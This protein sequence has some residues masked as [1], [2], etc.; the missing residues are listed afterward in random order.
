M[1]YR[2][3]FK[4]NFYL[5]A[6][7]IS[8]RNLKPNEILTDL[9][10][11]KHNYLRVSL[12]ERCNLRCEY[13]MP[14]DGAKL[15][16]KND[17][18]TNEEM[19]KLVSLFV[20]QGINKVR[21]T[22]GEP[23]VR[24]DIVDIVRSLKELN[25]LRTIAMTTNGLTLTRTLVNLQRAGLNALNIS[26]DTLQSQKYEKITRRDGGLL[27][28]VLVGIDLALQLG[29]NPVKVNCVLM[30]KFNLSEL[31][32]FVEFTR[33]LNVDY[34]FIEFMP[35]AMN[36]WDE[37]QLVPY[38]EAVEIITK[39][40]PNFQPCADNNTNATSKMFKVPEFKGRVGFITS[41]TDDYCDGCNRLRLMADGNLK[42]CLFQ[43]N[44]ISLRNPL[45]EGASEKELLDIISNAVKAKKR[46]HA[47]MKNLSKMINRPM[48]LI[49]G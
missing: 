18:L 42:A 24:K 14:V 27:K 2:L 16:K 11:R 25:G 6:R 10:G 40:F 19:L 39:K 12:T 23:T 48:V 36:K 49:G 9:F 44:E 21:I 45:R 28:R 13:C 47:G 15:S 31:C 34:R 26:L 46:K 1:I 3:L 5:K 20:K 33:N 17:L 29:F 8:T 4:Y 38:K 41:M 43:N 22:G 32:D 7:T 37:Q 30:R 35:F